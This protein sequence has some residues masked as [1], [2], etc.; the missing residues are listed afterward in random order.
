MAICMAER[1]L[2]SL[3]NNDGDDY[4][5]RHLKSEFA[6]LCFPSRL[7]LQRLANFLEL[8]SKGLYQSS[9]KKKR[10]VVLCF[11]PRQNVKS[12]TFTL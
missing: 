4:K 3:S 7:I 1:N 12:G 8:N 11:R 5:K 10:R 6:L 2:G 9:E